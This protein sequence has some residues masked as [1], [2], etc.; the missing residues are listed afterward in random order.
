MLSAGVNWINIFNISMID[1]C[2]EQSNNE[3][4]GC[5]FLYC[6]QIINKITLGTN[7]E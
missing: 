2:S 3:Q 7:D 4:N 5:T 6:T 1:T